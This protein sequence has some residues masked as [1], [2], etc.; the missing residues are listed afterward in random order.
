MRTLSSHEMKSVSGAGYLEEAVCLVDAFLFLGL[1][2]TAAAAGAWLGAHA[3]LKFFGLTIPLVA[4][5]LTGLHVVS[6]VSGAIMGANV[7]LA[8]YN[9][10]ASREDDCR[11]VLKL[12]Y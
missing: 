10:W 8:I 7:G 9:N 2:S 6:A 3:S 5:E 4:E 12:T 1:G 11:Q